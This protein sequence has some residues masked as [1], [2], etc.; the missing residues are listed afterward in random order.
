MAA[1]IH[2]QAGQMYYMQL[3]HVQN[4]GG[5]DEGVTARL[6]G[7]RI[8]IHR[9]RLLIGATLPGFVPFRPT[10]SI[11]EAAGGRQITYT[12]FAARNDPFKP[13]PTGGHLVEWPVAYSPFNPGTT[14]GNPRTNLFIEQVR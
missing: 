5:Y 2:L 1:L 4:G 10:I 11:A 7:R 8:R 14:P 6:R 13:S 3:E 9:Q 12:V